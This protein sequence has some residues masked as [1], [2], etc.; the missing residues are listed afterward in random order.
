MKTCSSCGE[1]QSDHLLYCAFC[2][3]KLGRSSPFTPFSNKPQVKRADDA[4][5]D[6]LETY[7]ETDYLRRT[8]SD[9]IIGISSV[10]CAIISIFANLFRAVKIPGDLILIEVILFSLS[11]VT[12]LLPGAIWSVNMHSLTFRHADTDHLEPSLSFHIRRKVS[13][14]LLL[15]LGLV[16]LVFGVS[17]IAG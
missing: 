13:S 3:E 14:A 12:A 6:F 1:K 7:E 8:L 17:W 10:V 9:T 2:G 16:L 15:V 11:A 5:K 4:P